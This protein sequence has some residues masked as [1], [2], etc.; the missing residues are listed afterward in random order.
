MI[1]NNLRDI[2]A[3]MDIDKHIEWIKS[4]HANV[5][6]IGCGGITSF[7]P[8]ALT[9]FQWQNPYMN[10]DFVGE[11]IKKAHAND[12]R[13]IVRFDFSKGHESF[14][15]KHNDWYVRTRDGSPVRYH[16]T[17]ATCINSEYQQKLSLKAIEE[18]IRKYPADGIFFNMFG[19]ITHDY[20]GNYI[21][22][23][24][25]ENCKKRFYEMYKEILPLE[26]NQ[27]DPVFIKYRE[28]QKTTV[29]DILGKIRDVTKAVNPDIAVSNYVPYAVDI[30]R[31]ES[32]SAVD[33]PLPFWLYNST[34]NVG[35][36]EGS[37]DDKVSSNV[38]INAVD[39]PY[40]FM[41]VSNYLNQIRLY[42]N[43]AA[44]G[45]LDWCIVG[46][47]D[48]Y[49]D[50]ENFEGVRKVFAFHEKYEQYYGHFEPKT[51]VMLVTGNRHWVDAEYRGIFRM[52]KEAHIQ[53]TIVEAEA[54]KDK[55]GDF[56]GYDFIILPALSQVEPEIAAALEKT[57]A[58]VIASK[59]SFADNPTL[60]EN[61]FG[62]RLG[63]YVTDVRGAYLRPEPK[64]DFPEFHE[65]K[66]VFLDKPYYEMALL[67]GAKGMLP[68]VEKARYGPPER[69]YGHVETDKPM[70][71]VKNGNL[72]VNWE[73]G[74][75]YYNLGYDEFKTLFLGLMRKVRPI[76]RNFET[77]A[78][79]MVEMFFSKIDESTYML[80][81]INMT[82]YNGMTFFKPLAVDFEVKFNDIIPKEVQEMHE[83]G[84]KQI[85]C[86]GK[87]N[88]HLSDLYKAFLVRV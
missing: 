42:G 64:S 32:N 34:H 8:T 28:F 27:D 63:E 19:Y 83:S 82:G 58:C 85:S 78:P 77:D 50:Y 79:E 23:C 26:E 41:G 46:N 55:V 15:D 47:F 73:I 88:V 9:D 48:D 70:A 16:D 60:L 66:W 39:L 11:L 75:L 36:I 13:V 30:V 53:F 14:Y 67:D 57:N 20:S 35:L 38:A 69:C 65:R 62:V 52:L 54:L 5:M 1:Q 87:L 2:D 71:A 76:P 22:I 18:V 56:N 4:F 61:L 40:R 17:V 49:T 44:G 51:K 74:S 24:Q 80:Q 43:M 29:Y 86:N 25:C 81:M 31:D 59:Y 37:Y 33:R 45:F 84:L 3:K 21:G 7:H 72:Y 10:S 68:K 12:I 6:Q